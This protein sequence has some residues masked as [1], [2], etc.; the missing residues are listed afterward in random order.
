MGFDIEFNAAVE[1]IARWTVAAASEN[2]G[3]GLVCLSTNIEIN[4]NTSKPHLQ[5]NL[6]F[7][8]TEP[9]VHIFPLDLET[10]QADLEQL[11]QRYPINIGQNILK[12]LNHGSKGSNRDVQGQLRSLDVQSAGRGWMMAVGEM[13][14]FCIWIRREKVDLEQVR[15]LVLGAQTTNGQLSLENDIT[16]N[17]QMDNDI[18]DN[19]FES[20]HVQ[21]TTFQDRTNGSLIQSHSHEEVVAGDPLHITPDLP[22]RSPSIEFLLRT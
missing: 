17:E 2:V 22:N 13:E 3:D 6:Y 21:K 12:D 18:P 16:N 15:T 8:S 9:A 10:K 14:K 1:L 20:P 11:K 5:R 19:E 7:P 4:S